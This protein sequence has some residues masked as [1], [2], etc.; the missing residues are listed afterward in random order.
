MFF[1]DFPQKTGRSGEFYLLKSTCFYQNAS[2]KGSFL[3]PGGAFFLSMREAC[4]SRTALLLPRGC[5]SKR[6]AGPPLIIAHI[7]RLKTA[8]HLCF[9]PPR[10]SRF[11]VSTDNCFLAQPKANRVYIM[12]LSTKKTPLKMQSIACIERKFRAA[13]L[14]FNTGKNNRPLFPAF[15][16]AAPGN[17]EQ[18][19][20]HRHNLLP[21]TN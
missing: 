16:Q 5:F 1:F 14:P 8:F 6:A 13:F 2:K 17:S 3:L 18:K 20:G 4:T 9:M 15:A 10:L 21:L 12:C 11:R 19:P 7:H